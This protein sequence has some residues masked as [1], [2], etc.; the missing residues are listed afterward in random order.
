VIGDADENAEVDPDL[1]TAHWLGLTDLATEGTFAW[2]TGS[3]AVYRN[4]SG[5]AAP[6]DEALDCAVL[7]DGG[8]WTNVDCETRY[9]YA[10]ECDPLPP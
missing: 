4:W 2:A 8:L 7:Q 9:P 5:G 6:V 1:A 10:C 3:P